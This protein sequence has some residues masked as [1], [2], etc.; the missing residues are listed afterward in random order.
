MNDGEIIDLTDEAHSVYN[1]IIRGDLEGVKIGDGTHKRLANVPFKITSKTTGESH[2][3]VTDAN[4][5]FS[6]SSEWVSHKQ[7]TN[8]GKSREDG[9]WF[10]TST[11]DDSKGAL[12]YDT[13]TI[14]E[15]RCDSNKGMTLIP[16]FDVVVSRNKTVIDLGTLTDDYEPE[17]SIHTTATDKA[18]G[19][20]M[21]V[22]GKDVTIIDTVTLDGLEKGTKY[23]LKG[24]E[25][26]KSENAELL[27]NGERVENDLAFTATDTKMEVQIEFTFNA[28]ELAGSLQEKS[29]SLLRNYTT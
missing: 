6:T 2:I 21:I 10:G 29:L 4:G 5:Q 3:I 7:N 20:K 19:E 22:A 25:M 1:Q 12:L 18:T 26:V 28:S 11:P 23:Q 17:S 27:V 8:A 15:L 16:A 24:W 9:I 14:E 13:Y